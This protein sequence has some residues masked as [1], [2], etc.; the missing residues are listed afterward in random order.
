MRIIE[1][2]RTSV[3]KLWH[4]IRRVYIAITYR[5]VKVVDGIHDIRICG[6][7]LTRRRKVQ[8]EGA[9]AYSPSWYWALDEIFKDTVFTSDDHL[10]DIGCGEGRVIAYL[11]EKKFPGHITGIEKDPYVV[12]VAKKWIEKKK[13]SK[14]NLIEGNA[15]EQDYN[16]YTVI[17]IFRPFSA[18][19]FERLIQRLEEQMLH[20]IKFYYLT[21][22]YS[23]S[24]LTGRQGWNMIKRSSV[25]R[26]YG[27]Y[28]WKCPQY[29]SVWEYD[30]TKET[31]T[32]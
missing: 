9:T 25:F 3:T 19:Y 28:I 2:F 23:R 7:N 5:I 27:L 17:Y 30:P 16:R 24:F 13:N 29:Y 8:V 6:Q 31:I 32:S 26:K 18:E 22:Y 1:L 14:V 10:V 12:D 4:L 11:L 20:P 15:L 21:D